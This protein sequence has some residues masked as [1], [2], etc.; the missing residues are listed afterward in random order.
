MKRILSILFA[1]C[2]I[3]LPAQAA[4]LQFQSDFGG[5]VTMATPNNGAGGPLSGNSGWWPILGGDDNFTW[6]ISIAGGSSQGLQPIANS[7]L[8]Y[9][10]TTTPPQIN[11]NGSK[12]FVAEIATGTRHDGTTGPMLH[13]ARYQNFDG[14]MQLPYAA[15]PGTSP[16]DEYQSIWMMLPSNLA[17][18]MGT[19]GWRTFSEFK[20]DTSSCSTGENYCWRWILFVYTDSS[21]KLYWDMQGSN[22]SSSGSYFDV[23]NKTTPVPVG[24][25]FHYEMA[26]HRTCN[27][28]TDW[29]WVKIDGVQI[30]TQNGGQFCNGSAPI[31]RIFFGQLYGNQNV[32]NGP[33]EQWIDHIE[34]WDAVPG[35]SPPP[36]PP[37][38]PVIS[39][40]SPTSGS[41]AGGT[42][43]T[44]TGTGL[45]GATSVLFGSVAASGFS[46]ANDTSISATS[47][48][49]GAGMVDITVTTP[50]GTSAT[51]SGDKFTYSAP[52]PS[53]TSS[54]STIA[55]SGSF[56]VTWANMPAATS[57][58]WIGF[59]PAGQPFSYSVH[60][61]RPPV[62]ATSG[63]GT[64]SATT[65]TGAAAPTGNY[66]VRYYNGA[67]SPSCILE[68]QTA[69]ITVAAQIP[70][71]PTGTTESCSS[72]AR[73][74][75][76]AVPGA[77][78]YDV[79][80]NGTK[81]GSPASAS[82][83]DSTGAPSTSYSYT[84]D[85]FNSSGTSAQSSAVSVQTCGP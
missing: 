51:G 68:A 5:T 2:M 38:G 19:N 58:D 61:F 42:A 9:V 6:P 45:T 29:L 71:V 73:L 7:A 21:G 85:A 48:A 47:P 20:T 72:A 84:V 67:C 25:W 49:E 11:A 78:G 60:Y 27:T 4:N 15:N 79:F 43:V 46:V 66:N 63:S 55:P 53:I 40:I 54:V 39:S 69:T 14:V 33:Q 52:G 75:W 18:Q 30:L 16:T 76:N 35:T 83:T 1:L 12:L 13:Q 37:P 81:I 64:M 56:T 17:A 44:I 77:T 34:V 82:F 36:P 70:A 41:T 28:T 26:F 3:S 65:S 80:R 24:K 10:G 23:S 22:V 32:A 57:N 50:N 31:N 59:Y 74:S 8:S 62:G